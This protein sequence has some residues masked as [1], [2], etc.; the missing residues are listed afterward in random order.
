MAGPALILSA[1][2]FFPNYTSSCCVASLN[3]SEKQRAMITRILIKQRHQKKKEKRSEN[4]RNKN[5]QVVDITLR[6]DK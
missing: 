2:V 6:N 1:G 5:G 3:C 4:M